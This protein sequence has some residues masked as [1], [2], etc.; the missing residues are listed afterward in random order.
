MSRSRRTIT[1]DERTLFEAAVDGSKSERA[2]RSTDTGIPAPPPKAAPPPRKPSGVDGRTA[3]RLRKGAIEPEGRLDLHGL[4]EAAAHQALRTFMR[5]S[6]SGGLRLVLVI[7]GK[8]LKPS[9]PDEPFDLELDRRTRGVLRAMVPRWL[10]E[11]EFVRS[12]ADV[13]TAHRRH[14]GAGALY[15]YLRKERAPS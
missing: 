12:V 13:R 6:I 10:Q 3:E 2:T 1:E 9:A 4:T 11:P 7:T 5:Q 14:G 8:G 15:I